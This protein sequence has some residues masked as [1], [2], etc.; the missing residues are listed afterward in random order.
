MPS[1]AVGEIVLSFTIVIIRLL[2]RGYP[3]MSNL[4]QG[5]NGV[6]MRIQIQNANHVEHDARITTVGSSPT[7]GRS[8]ENFQTNLPDSSGGRI[9]ARAT[10][11]QS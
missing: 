11:G 2:S 6:G 9:G 5:S 8:A 4:R 10:A 1:K 3:E 7:S